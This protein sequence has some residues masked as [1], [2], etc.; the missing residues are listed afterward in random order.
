MWVPYEGGRLHVADPA[1][2]HRA[3][4]TADVGLVPGHLEAPLLGHDIVGGVQHCHAFDRLE[5]HVE[6]TGLLARDRRW[7]RGGVRKVD[8]LGIGLLNGRQRHHLG[9]DLGGKRRTTTVGTQ[10]V[11]GACSNDDGGRRQHAKHGPALQF[12]FV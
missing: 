6:S 8:L 11:V 5:V 7:N 9:H 10:I 3:R 12:R 1:A 2:D 4:N